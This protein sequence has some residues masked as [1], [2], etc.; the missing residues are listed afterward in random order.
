MI[1]RPPRSTLFPYTTLF[2]SRPQLRI[3]AERRAQATP[4]LEPG[5]RGDGSRGS[6]LAVPAH[7]PELE[8]L[9]RLGI[10]RLEHEEVPPFVI[11]AR[12]LAS[13][14]TP[15]ATFGVREFPHRLL[16]DGSEVMCA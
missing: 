4:Q 6:A 12:L 9:A 7:F 14:G 8:R 15:A 16:L 1:R 10:H 5:H 11:R 2:R 13:R 3:P